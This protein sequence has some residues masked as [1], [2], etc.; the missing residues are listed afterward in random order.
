MQ[1]NHQRI[2][3]RASLLCTGIV[4]DRQ[5]CEVFALQG[6]DADLEPGLSDL[7]SVVCKCMMWQALACW[8]S[9]VPSVVALVVPSVV[10][11]GVASIIDTCTHC[12]LTNHSDSS[13]R[14]PVVVPIVPMEIAGQ[15]S[16]VYH[17][18]ISCLHNAILIGTMHLATSVIT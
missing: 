6:Q 8:A 1:V 3:S 12:A 7:A 11:S 13:D 4:S 17:P 9:A 5:H 2:N 14:E 10:A 16:Q 18:S 15:A